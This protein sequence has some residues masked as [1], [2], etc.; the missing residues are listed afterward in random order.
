MLILAAIFKLSAEYIIVLA[1]VYLFFNFIAGVLSYLNGVK[2]AR[3]FVLG[4]GI[5]AICYSIAIL[6]ALGVVSIIEK[7]PNIVLY[8]TAIEALILSVAFA[9]RY[10]I[11]EKEKQKISA[12]RL[13]E[14]H[15]RR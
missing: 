7:Q 13:A 9:D 6:D 11:L 4:F 2:E 10:T 15:N 8:A 14:S 1:L 5:V 12:L 3:L